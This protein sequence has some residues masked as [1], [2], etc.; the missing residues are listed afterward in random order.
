MVRTWIE[1]VD[2]PEM[3]RSRIQKLPQ[4]HADSYVSLTDERA[5]DFPFAQNFRPADLEPPD[6]QAMK[7][8]HTRVSV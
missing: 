4:G 7:D 5:I 2:T 8:G 3:A 1:G 6:E